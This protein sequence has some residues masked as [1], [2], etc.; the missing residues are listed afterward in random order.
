MLDDAGLAEEGDDPPPRPARPRLRRVAALLAVAVVA[1][2]V[3]AYATSARDAARDE[4]RAARAVQLDVVQVSVSRTD[5]GTP[6]E[7]LASLRNRGPRGLQVRSAHLGRTV[8]EATGSGSLPAGGVWSATGLVPDQ[9]SGLADLLGPLTVE[10]ATVDGT[11]RSVQLQPG[12]DY[13]LDGGLPPDVACEPPGFDQAYVQVSVVGSAKRGA[14]SSRLQLELEPQLPAGMR[15]AV[16]TGVEVGERGVVARTVSGV[17]ATLATG[18]PVRVVVDV[19]APRCD[20]VQLPDDPTG[21]PFLWFQ[22]RG[23]PVGVPSTAPGYE[24]NAVLVAV[25]RMLA[26]ACPD[27]VAG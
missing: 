17:P 16:L 8:L 4:A 13:V 18:V 23:L 2:A 25:L 27:L 24:A 20:R 3:G 9:C 6:G 19:S 1:A 12:R 10:V 7:V 11:A 14:R 5:A 22:G 26:R 15:R 21:G